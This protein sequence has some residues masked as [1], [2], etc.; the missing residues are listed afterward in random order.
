MLWFF[1]EDLLQKAE[2]LSDYELDSR[3]QVHVVPDVTDVLVSP[4]CVVTEFCDGFS[5]CS[6]WADVEPQSCSFSEERAHCVT[7]A[8]EERRYESSQVKASP[9]SRSRMRPPTPLQNSNDAFEEAQE[10]FVVDDQ[11]W[12]AR[13]RTIIARNK[14]YLEES[15]SVKVEVRRMGRSAGSG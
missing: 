14:Q 13:E 11:M 6:D 8:Q 3:A 10:R 1:L 4:T 7:C 2:D 9:I 12:S 5:C 15:Y